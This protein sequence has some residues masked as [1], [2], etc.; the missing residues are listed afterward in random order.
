MAYSKVVTYDE[1]AQMFI[2]NMYVTPSSGSFTPVDISSVK[3]AI[4]YFYGLPTSVGNQCVCIDKTLIDNNNIWKSDGTNTNFLTFWNRVTSGKIS[5]N[6]PANKVNQNTNPIRFS[7]IDDK[8]LLSEDK[9]NFYGVVFNMH[10]TL[11]DAK[12]SYSGHSVTT[13]KI[14]FMLKHYE[15]TEYRTIGSLIYNTQKL[16]SCPGVFTKLGLDE[17]GDSLE[18]KYYVTVNY[19]DRTCNSSG[20]VIE[21]D[22]TKYDL[23]LISSTSTSATFSTTVSGNKVKSLR[24]LLNMKKIGLG[25]SLQ[26]TSAP[27]TPKITLKHGKI[28]AWNS[29]SN[30]VVSIPISGNSQFP[31][32]SWG[33]YSGTSVQLH[34][35]PK[36][37]VNEEHKVAISFTSSEPLEYTTSSTNLNALANGY[38]YY[39]RVPVKYNGNEYYIWTMVRKTNNSITMVD[40]NE[41]FLEVLEEGVPNM[42]YVTGVSSVNGVSVYNFIQSQY[43]AISLT[44]NG[45]LTGYGLR[46][47]LNKLW[48][49]FGRTGY[50]KY[51]YNNSPTLLH[52]GYISSNSYAQ[53]YTIDTAKLTTWSSILGAITSNSSH[54]RYLV[55]TTQ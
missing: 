48:V 16:Y 12:Y 44:G 55:S 13:V 23:N 39:V 28:D 33:S 50:W 29:T 25:L 42:G 6:C 3:S 4:S 30:S 31:S 1:F 40:D 21:I 51:N 9:L 47:G 54:Y 2:D 22:D 46:F 52:N 35:Y 19:S 43:E 34:F 11:V 41:M 38:D 14:D 37:S 53:V 7:S 18:W 27:T 45:Y 26:Q 17:Q 15:D 5:V 36:S 8:Q 20:H 32:V 24:S 10:Q 49:K